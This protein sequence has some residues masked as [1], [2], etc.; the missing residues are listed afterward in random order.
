MYKL[1]GQPDWQLILPTVSPGAALVLRSQDRVRFLAESSFA[2]TRQMTFRAWDQSMWTVGGQFPTAVG[3]SI[4]KGSR[5]AQVTITPGNDRPILDAKALHPLTSVAPDNTN[6]PGDAVSALLGGSVIDPDGPSPQGI[7]VT[8]ADGKNG[9]WQFSTDGGS[10][11]Q[12]V[13][14]VSKK[15]ALLL[16]TQDRIRFV[17][18]AGYHGTAKLTYLAWDQSSGAAGDKVT[19]A[20][21][22]VT[23][24]SLLSATS[25]VKVNAA[26]TLNA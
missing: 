23:A 9:R 14:V 18:N 5:T 20:G 1:S 25:V 22:G 13:G 15:L 26:P 16:R 21:A 11:W 8:L 12:D 2:G 4:S 10:S 3:N 7:A 24:F 6:P 19:T 17:P